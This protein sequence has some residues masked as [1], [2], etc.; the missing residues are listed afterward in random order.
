MAR[1]LVDPLLDR[2]PILW[3]GDRWQTYLYDANGQT[4]P[5]LDGIVALQHD[6]TGAYPV[7]LVATAGTKAIDLMAPAIGALPNR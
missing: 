5:N 6:T 3:A 4:Y 2:R 7:T 1:V